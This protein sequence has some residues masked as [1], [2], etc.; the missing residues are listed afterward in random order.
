V[1]CLIV[2][3][4][5]PGKPPY[6]LQIN[7]NNNNN[8]PEH[9]NLHCESLFGYQI[10]IGYFGFC[11]CKLLVEKPEGKRPL[12]RSRRR[13]LNNIKTDFKWEWGAVNWIYL[14]QDRDQWSALVSRQW[15]PIGLSDGINK[16]Q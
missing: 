8:I 7:N 15:E 6:A 2:V 3:P 11:L 1:L 4:Q 5:P 10:P 9:N 13:R 16:I 14:T 12:G